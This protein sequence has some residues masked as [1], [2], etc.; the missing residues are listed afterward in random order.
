MG[1][2]LELCTGMFLGSLSQLVGTWIVYCFNIDNDYCC[3]YI[4]RCLRIR[5][6]KPG[7]VFCVFDKMSIG[8]VMCVLKDTCDFRSS[9]TFIIFL[10]SSVMIC[11]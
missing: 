10:S 4:H 8:L 3:V 7:L 6:N 1:A 5:D 11:I 9:I 2:I